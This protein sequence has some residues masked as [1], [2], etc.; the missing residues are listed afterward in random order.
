MKRYG[1]LKEDHYP[2]VA[3]N[4]SKGPTFQKEKRKRKRKS[5][6]R[7]KIKRKI[8]IKR[9]RKQNPTSRNLEEAAK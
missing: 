4:R 7:R 6:R 3:F 9:K 8:K 2:H 5:K 1:G